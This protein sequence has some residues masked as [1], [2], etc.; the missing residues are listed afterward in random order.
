MKGIFFLT[1]FLTILCGV[2]SAQGV[3]RPELPADEGNDSLLAFPAGELQTNNYFMPGSFLF[4]GQDYTNFKLPEFDFNEGLLNWKQ[5]FSYYIFNPEGYSNISYPFT[6]FPFARAA[7]VFNQAAYK[8]SDKFTFGGNSFGVQSVFTV[9]FPNQG[10]N[11]F[12]VRGA[13]MFLQYKVSK[14]IKIETRVNV[15][16]RQ[17]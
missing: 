5:D 4:L 11:S 3:I 14:N 12:D 8:L 2:A 10:L 13:S 16:N 6:A 17:F 1:A 9:P 15:T 7:T